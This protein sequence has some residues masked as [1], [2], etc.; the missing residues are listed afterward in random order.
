MPVPLWPLKEWLDNVALGALSSRETVEASFRLA[1]SAIAAGIPGDFVECGVYNGSQSAAMARAAYYSPQIR[2][3]HLFD[4]FAG[5]PASG[6]H[7]V[8]FRQAGH[9][10][11]TSACSLES[12][13][14]HMAEWSLPE[15][16]FVYHQ[17]LFIDTAFAVSC[18][19]SREVFPN[20]IAVLRL[21]GD[22]YES[23]R[24]CLPL[25]DLVNPG[26]WIIV[27]DYHLDGCRQAITEKLG[28]PSP[29]AFKKHS[30]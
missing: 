7:D 25:I 15:Q 11:G 1:V 20:G 26:G 27:D 22:L 19:G 30:K 8:E 10:P 18:M 17:G 24:D 6:P 3:V 21:D 9:P 28:F 14:V 23:T 12:V 2:R 4:T 13:K 29:I 16:L 5:I